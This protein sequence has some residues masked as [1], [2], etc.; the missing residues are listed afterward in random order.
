MLIYRTDLRKPESIEF[1][2]VF[3]EAPATYKFEPRDDIPVNAHGAAI[4][5]PVVINR[6]LSIPGYVG[7]GPRPQGAE[8]A[9]G[10]ATIEQIVTARL[11]A[12][13]TAVFRRD[14]EPEWTPEAM[15]AYALTEGRRASVIA[16]VPE[17]APAPVEA[18]V[19]APSVIEPAAAVEPA[20]EPVE[21][22]TEEEPEMTLGEARTLYREVL[23]K[24]PSPRWDIDELLDKIEEH[25]A[26]IPPIDPD[27]DA[28]E[29]AQAEAE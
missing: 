3:G 13:F 25:Q 1:T 28:E 7:V 29:E 27:G 5:D 17:P 14:P 15:F 26:G 2:G 24:G 20:P 23:G 9:G 11:A 4:D 6:L 22:E 8:A 16:A 12:A 19:E 21:A 18:P 10:E